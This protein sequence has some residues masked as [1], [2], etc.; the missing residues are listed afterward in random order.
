MMVGKIYNKKGLS[1][2]KEKVELMSFII[3]EK[4][5]LN[6][7]KKIFLECLMTADEW[8]LESV[9]ELSL[10]HLKLIHPCFPSF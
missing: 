2:K 6:F 10:E 3:P 8:R 9:G 4:V 5:C 7:R 1:K